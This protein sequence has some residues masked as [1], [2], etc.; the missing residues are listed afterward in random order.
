MALGISPQYSFF[1][2]PEGD[3]FVKSQ[4]QSQGAKPSTRIKRL[5]SS[6]PKT[7]SK[8][9]NG[10]AKLI[11]LDSSTESVPVEV[12]ELKKA[13]KH[14]LS[15]ERKDILENTL[16]KLS[17]SNDVSSLLNGAH[18]LSEDWKAHIAEIKSL[19][20]RE[21][22]EKALNVQESLHQGITNLKNNEM[23]EEAKPLEA[24]AKKVQ[25]ILN[26]E[27]KDIDIDDSEDARDFLNLAREVQ[28]LA[29]QMEQTNQK[30]PAWLAEVR[31]KLVKPTKL[32]IKELGQSTAVPK[33]AAQKGEA[34]RVATEEMISHLKASKKLIR[35]GV[36]NQDVYLG[37]TAVFKRTQGAR[38]AEEEALADGIGQIFDPD[39]YAPQ[40]VV[41][42]LNPEK[43]GIALLTPEQ[44]KQAIPMEALD[45]PDQKDHFKALQASLKAPAGATLLQP[46]AKKMYDQ[47]IKALNGYRNGI[48]NAEIFR[49]LKYKDFLGNEITFDEWATLNGSNLQDPVKQEAFRATRMQKPILGRL[50]PDFVSDRPSTEAKHLEKLFEKGGNQRWEIQ[51]PSTQKW[52]AVTSYTEVIL[53]FATGIEVR[54]QG[55]DALSSQQKTDLT[56]LSTPGIIKYQPA[57]LDW[58]TESWI[59]AQTTVKVKIKNMLTLET[60]DKKGLTAKFLAKVTNPAE[61]A[62]AVRALYVQPVDLHY[63]NIG[64]SPLL[65]PEHAADYEDAKFSY[66]QCKQV[67]LS[68]I[69]L[70][71]LAGDLDGDTSVEC[72]KTDNSKT[73][74]PIKLH[75]GLLDTLDSDWGF[76][77]FD[78]D[79]NMFESNGLLQYGPHAVAPVR[80]MLTADA[81]AFKP[82]SPQV[83]Q[84]LSQDA[85]KIEESM[86]YL[87]NDY[88]PLLLRMTSDE[89]EE[90]RELLDDELSG[91]SLGNG[92][93]K[94]PNNL[95]ILRTKFAINLAEDP[96]DE[97]WERL[98][99]TLNTYV[100]PEGKKTTLAQLAEKQH[101]NAD[102]LLK[103]NPSL[104]SMNDALGAG[105]R[106]ELPP[107]Y[108]PSDSTSTMTQI[109][110]LKNVPLKALLEENQIPL[111]FADQPLIQ[112]QEVKIPSLQSDALKEKRKEIAVQLFP[113]AT[114]AQQNAFKERLENQAKYFRSAAGLEK[115]DILDQSMDESIDLILQKV[116]DPSIPLSRAQRYNDEQYLK[117]VKTV[118]NGAEKTNRVSAFQQSFVEKI[119]P[120]LANIIKV[121][122]PIT[123][124]LFELLT[125]T[126]QP[127]LLP[128]TQQPM[129]LLPD[130]SN[131]VGTLLQRA[132]QMGL[133][134]SNSPAFAAIINEI[135][136][137]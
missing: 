129:L 120:S 87:K 61:Q 49:E 58:V 102:E 33:G 30:I 118:P 72:I 133:N 130:W 93:F 108:I 46:S 55:T 63:G 91:Y 127:M 66:G 24:Y 97:I 21:K 115:L 32:A 19:S 136:S 125:I 39:L 111:S 104:A 99:L 52:V 25:H 77:F 135:S 137:L 132:Q 82:L 100:V 9:A 98:D 2:S 131:P 12:K 68:Q 80:Y 53:A 67:P 28:G 27:L 36:S 14:I 89:K 5:D 31:T 70:D 79:Q 107:H 88:H 119:R 126:R 96:S 1:Q 6:S 4:S 23:G 15:P 20:G 85:N 94:D 121:H 43:L 73:T 10:T 22:I 57:S 54:T 75:P 114:I 50:Y 122:Y 81:F 51:L 59:G 18:V 44:E 38:S 41:K 86:R 78:T 47:D 128:I 11:K 116:Q 84:E 3:L 37:E 92:L 40:L 101:V 71:Y 112:G 105:T 16:S 109:A 34:L 13:I 134:P 106:L 45:Q 65:A 62:K 83:V 64:L 90:F 56:S 42:S 123:A 26:K 48:A 95:S 103:L 29:Q 110:Q 60:I 76:K 69:M 35:A 17:N 124:E 113:K 117:W 8:I 74:V 7:L